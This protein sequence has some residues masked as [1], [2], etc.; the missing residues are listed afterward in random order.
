M[1]LKKL[2]F[3]LIITSLLSSSCSGGGNPYSLDLE[4][5]PNFKI[6]W[7]TDIHYGPEADTKS[8][9]EFAHLDKIIK[10]AEQPDLIII[11]GD[12]FRQANKSHVNEFFSFIDSYGIKWAFTFGN[13]D[14]ETFQDS[15]DFISEEI[16]KCK[17]KVYYDNPKD[18]I[19]GKAN[20]YIN[21]KSGGKTIYRLYLTDSNADFNGGYDVIHEDQLKHME[22]IAENNKDSA[23][24]LVFIHIPLFQF[25]SAWDGY[26][27]GL[28][29]GQ[30]QNNETCCIPYIDNGAYQVFK[31]IGIKACFAGHDHLNYADIDYKGEMILSYGLK[32]NDLD[33]H[34]DAICGYKI[35]S[36]P[37]DSNSFGLKDIQMHSLLMK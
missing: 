10:D 15:P 32:A 17:N 8:Q 4:Y 14:Q 5:K 33:Y 28:Y 6:L 22:Q 21:L 29:Q 24:N 13:H 9:E 37:E 16:A 7:L 34:D 19:Y 31:K 25:Q 35:I 3:P 20:Y 1:N 26:K 2:S 11:T 23:V 27:L 12:S 30:G 18:N 36:L